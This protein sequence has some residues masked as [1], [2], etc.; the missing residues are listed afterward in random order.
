MR[1]E[2]P[3]F[4]LS[5]VP[6]ALE[7]C[8]DS[9]LP[10]QQL[11]A[12][13]EDNIAALRGRIKVAGSRVRY[14]HLVPKALTDEVPMVIV[15]GYCGTESAYKQLAIELA[16]QGR[17][18]VYIRPPRTQSP[19]MAMRPDHIRDVL[20]LQAQATW[21]TIKGI[22]S[23][24]GHELYDLY[25]HSMGVPIA[26]KTA[27]HKPG[28]IRYAILAG[29]AGQNGHNTLP[30]MLK[31]TITVARNDVA[32]GHQD[33]TRYVHPTRIALDTAHHVL[34]RPDRTVREGYAV[35]RI[36]DRDTLRRLGDTSVKI[37][38]ILFEKDGYFPP[39]EVLAASGDYFDDVEITPGAT[40]IYPQD[41]PF[42]HADDVHAQVK[43]LILGRLAL[44][45]RA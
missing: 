25:G 20:K 44:Q 31:K 12:L 16:T 6:I 34:R 38:A 42:E 19:F 22:R 36:D 11:E 7:R 43:R 37:G 29:G 18:V 40:H 5:V 30:G 4:E 35:A 9:D 24:T 45:Q 15:N 17:E 13:Q 41:H 14:T 2:N 21:G 10:R 8:N 27:V 26:T 32:R 3:D 28:Y 39:S 23:Y 33:I 1:I